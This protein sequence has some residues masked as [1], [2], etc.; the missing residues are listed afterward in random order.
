MDF[1]PWIV[2]VPIDQFTTNTFADA[3][4]QCYLYR[5]KIGEDENGEPVYAWPIIEMPWQTRSKFY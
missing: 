4:H 3:V 2:H 5:K 1:G